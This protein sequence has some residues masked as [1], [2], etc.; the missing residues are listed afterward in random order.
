MKSV[1]LIELSPDLGLGGGVE[2][3]RCCCVCLVGRGRGAGG[4][5]LV[6]EAEDDVEEE[7]GLPVTEDSW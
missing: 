2:T 4:A 3:L 5:A 7:R 6:D 1:G